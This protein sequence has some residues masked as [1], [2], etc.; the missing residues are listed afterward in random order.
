MKEKH[1][2]FWVLEDSLINFIFFPS[3]RQNKL[4]KKSV[5]RLPER[6]NGSGALK[7]LLKTR[8]TTIQYARH[9][10]E[11]IAPLKPF[12]SSDK[13]KKERD[14]QRVIQWNQSSDQKW[15]YQHSITSH[16]CNLS[17]CCCHCCY[18]WIIIIKL[19]PLKIIRTMW[20]KDWI[21]IRVQV[22]YCDIT[23]VNHENNIFYFF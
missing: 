15:I 22:D 7:S 8:R 19:M 21:L 6:V 9:K 12:K 13:P 1:T 23:R 3:R 4:S 17:H 10:K 20:Q 2:K 16:Q 14:I 18:C 5:K 11:F